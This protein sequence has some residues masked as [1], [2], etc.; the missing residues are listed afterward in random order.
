M[1]AFRD[2][3]GADQDVDLAAPERLQWLPIRFFPGH[4]LSVHPPDNGRGKKLHTVRLHFLGAE[5]G[6]DQRV[7][8]T[9]RA[10]LWDGSGMPTEMAAQSRHAPVKSQRDAA[11]RAIPGL[12]A[13]AAKK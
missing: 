3:L 2:H 8:R 6:V 5:P 13:V 1:Q 7:L 12:A 9:G 4:G 11:V 10:F